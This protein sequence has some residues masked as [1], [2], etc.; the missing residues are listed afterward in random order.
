MGRGS[1]RKEADYNVKLFFV[2]S[3]FDQRPFEIFF[4][5]V[6]AV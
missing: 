4:S 5:V 1:N 2:L 6:G 3:R